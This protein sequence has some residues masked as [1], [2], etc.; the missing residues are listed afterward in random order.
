MQYID[1]DKLKVTKAGA[2]IIKA[3]FQTNKGT[4][5]LDGNLFIGEKK[6]ISSMQDKSVVC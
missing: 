3:I 1:P 4:K 2:Y 6:G 5:E